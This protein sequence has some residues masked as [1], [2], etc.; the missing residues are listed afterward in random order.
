MTSKYSTIVLIGILMFFFALKSANAE[1]AANQFRYV[2][3][4]NLVINFADE[5]EKSG[6]KFRISA[7]IE[8]QLGTLTNLELYFASSKDLKVISNTTELKQLKAGERRKV[9]ILAVKTGEATDQMGT[10]LKLGIRYTPDYQ[11]IIAAVS[12]EGKFPDQVERQRLI[13][14]ARRNQ[15]QNEQYHM[16]ARFFPEK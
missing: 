6:N 12:D 4:N 1:N 9:K 11:A 10:W 2:F 5:I 8:G 13:D 7:I 14:I 3:P 15:S 16:S